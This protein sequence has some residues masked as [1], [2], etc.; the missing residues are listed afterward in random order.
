L[1]CGIHQYRAKTGKQLKNYWM[2]PSSQYIIAIGILA[3]AYYIRGISGYG[4][5]LLAIPSLALFM[6]LEQVVPFIAVLDFL[7]ALTHGL[8]YRKLVNW[9]EL[10]VLIPIAIMGMGIGLMVFSLTDTESLKPGLGIFIILYAIY[11][12]LHI[13][14]S[15]ATRIWSVPLVTTGGIV[16]TLFGTGG[17]F[18]VIYLRFRKMDKT[19]FVATIAMT[20]MIATGIRVS[21]YGMAGFY[22]QELLEMILLAIPIMILF[23]YLGV[24]THHHLSS[25][26]FSYI[27]SALLIIAGISLLVKY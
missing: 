5:G 13:P 12:L 19:R 3:I 11:S 8:H 15:S 10:L 7:A 23:L 18:Y 20:F 2:E 25:R 1:V 24:R 14:Q 22:P 6:P 17:P 16:D 9:R 27:L 21:G 26:Q 4:S